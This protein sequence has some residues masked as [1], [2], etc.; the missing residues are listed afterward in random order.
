[1]CKHVAAVL[2][3]VGARLDQKPE[4]LFV[5]R[6]VDQSELLARVGADLPLAKAAPAHAKVLGDD[7]AILFG[8]DMAETPAALA[9]A[10]AFAA[11]RKHRKTAGHS[12]ALA[13][14]RATRVRR[15]PKW[16]ALARTRK[17]R[18]ITAGERD[19][20]REDRHHPEADSCP[21]TPTQGRLS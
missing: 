9:P 20:Q 14:T 4:L 10:V 19:A 2:Y 12:T 18:A 6:G 11:P 15:E 21:A 8:L 13:A 5:L 17:R 16:V 1:M 3:G 7:V